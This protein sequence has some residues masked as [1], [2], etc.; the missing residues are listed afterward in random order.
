MFFARFFQVMGAITLITF[1]GALGLFSAR[2]DVRD[3]YNEYSV[4]M[5]DPSGRDP[6]TDLLYGQTNVLN[7]QANLNN[8]QAQK[9]LAEATAIVAQ[10]VYDDPLYVHKQINA[11]TAGAFNR[12]MMFVVFGIF[13]F[14]AG[15]VVIGMLKGGNASASNSNDKSLAPR[16]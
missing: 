16:R 15:F 5:V 8:A 10:S 7:S 13:L 2:N 6:K 9:Y 4:P 1:C 14:V 12:G 3:G 11:E